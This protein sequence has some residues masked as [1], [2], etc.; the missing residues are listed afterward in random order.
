M[1]E[2][3]W[4]LR[5]C[6]SQYAGKLDQLEMVSMN[7]DQKTGHWFDVKHHPYDSI[8]WRS[9]AKRAKKTYITYFDLD[10]IMR[11][12][13]DDGIRWELRKRKEEE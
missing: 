9:L 1:K 13:L 2:L 3:L 11:L 8:A 5:S 10:I 7:M 6:E 12:I 4:W